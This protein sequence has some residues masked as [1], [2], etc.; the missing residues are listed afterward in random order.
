MGFFAK[1]LFFHISH[2]L[3]LGSKKPLETS[4]LL[5]LPKK[6]ECKK[7]TKRFNRQYLLA[8]KKKKGLI[9][10]LNRT[11]GKAFWPG[12]I[13][14]LLSTTFT[15]LT[16]LF[17][18]KILEVIEG[19]SDDY[20][21]KGMPYVFSFLITVFVQGITNSKV[22]LISETTSYRIRSV[23]ISAI[24]QKSLK[25]NRKTLD[26]SKL[27]L[28]KEKGNDKEKEK[29]KEKEKIESSNDEGKIKRKSERKADKAKKTEK[30]TAKEKEKEKENAEATLGQIVNLMSTDIDKIQF[31]MKF[32]LSMIGMII[33]I[34]VSLILLVNYLGWAAVI[35]LGVLLLN[36][37]MN[38]FCLNKWFGLHTSIMTKADLRIKR[39]NE[40]LQAIKLIKLYAWEKIFKKKVV[41]IREEELTY[42]KSLMMWRIVFLMIWICLPLF[43][44]I[45]TYFS[46]VALGNKLTP[47]KVFT[48]LSLF[49]ILR[50]PL[51]L[52]PE[53]MSLVVS[54]KVS[55]IRIENFLSFEEIDQES[56][57]LQKTRIVDDQKS[58]EKKIT[59]KLKNAS[60]SWN[61]TEEELESSSSKTNN[62]ANP[63]LD[64][65]TDSS[66]DQTSRMTSGSEA[67]DGEEKGQNNTSNTLSDITLEI[68]PHHLTIIVGPVGSGKSSLLSAI[69]GEIPKTKGK[70]QV[71]G[72][73][74]YSSQE[75]WIRNSTLR[76]NILWQNEYNVRRYN[77][78][79]NIC[80]LE[81]DL[82]M[83]PAGDLTEIGEKG[84]NL[85]GG[86]KARVS[87]AR[88]VYSD[89]DI[90]LL[91][92]PLSAIDVHVGKHI[93]HKCIKG[94][95]LQNK[96][97]VLVTHQLQYLP[98][99]DQLIIIDSGKVIA[100]GTYHELK[101]QD[102]DFTK[103]LTSQSKN[104][105][106]KKKKNM[107]KN[108]KNNNNK[109]K[110]K[111]KKKNIKNKNIKKNKDGDDN[112]MKDNGGDEK[113]ISKEKNDMLWVNLNENEKY[114]QEEIKV[115][116]Q[117]ETASKSNHTS[118]NKGKLIN[119]E[120][121]EIGKVKMDHY[122]FYI[123]AAGKYIALFGFL[124]IVLSMLMGTAINFWLAIWT[125]GTIIKN[126]S[127]EYYITWYF[128]FGI[129]SVIVTFIQGY[130]SAVGSVNA[131]RNIHNNLFDRISTSP[132]K[133]F[134]IT[135]IG[136][137]LNRFNKDIAC[138][139]TELNDGLFSVV[140]STLIVFGIL[141][142]IAIVTPI[143][144]LP[145]IAIVYLYYKIINYFRQT[146]REI[147]RL[148]SI[149]RSPVFSNF[150]ETLNGLQ[151]IRA[152][153][154]Q[155]WMVRENEGIVNRLIEIEHSKILT[156]CWLEIRLQFCGAI[157]IFFASLFALLARNTISAA[158]AALSIQR[159]MSV[160]FL[161]NWMV[162]EIADLERKMNSIE[163]IRDYT[164]LAKE[165]PY[166]IPKSKPPKAWPKR[167]KI[168]FQ[169]L[170][171]K[172]R[173]EL[174]P[175]LKNISLTIEPTEKI[176]VI[177]RTGSGK[178]SLMMCLFRIVEY[179]KGKILIDGVDIAKMGLY[180][181]RS[182]LGII[183][184][185]PIL[186]EG[187][188][189]SNL[190]PYSDSES[191][192][193]L[194]KRKSDLELWEA[195]HCAQL[196][197]KVQSLKGQLDFQI[198]E[199]GDNFSVGEK[200]LFCLARA[201][202]KNAQILILDEA[203]ANVDSKT[204]NIIQQTIRTKFKMCTVITI[205]HRLN[206]VMDSDKILALE[207]GKV[208]EFDKPKKLLKNPKGLLY[209]LVE[210]T[211]NEN[212]QY[213]R[214]IAF[215]AIKI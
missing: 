161:S 200:Q 85:S 145:T 116:T 202:L 88:A 39:V 169:N 120:E 174:E 24:F 64:N 196:K 5:Q 31:A 99:A 53:L 190:D 211:G 32:F 23:L 181:L 182:K 141:I 153:N 41:S 201:V 186:F 175:V 213:L 60:F 12:L 212:S 46:Y 37:P 42:V 98:F 22:N 119:F 118:Q 189:R 135:P 199:G 156:E 184:Q 129:I 55:V 188:I 204:D 57:E 155:E 7:L 29:E 8:Q 104:N 113:T 164:E 87:L 26:L 1:L 203:T 133:F 140:A 72:T 128:I 92:D 106:K 138:V 13:P 14:A 93:F 123:K 173:P 77:K 197:K 198:T 74:A 70:M 59:I 102:F 15:L 114:F 109:N 52:V 27:K 83:L 134:E 9:W 142:T 183:P 167:G 168:E 61:K 209:R 180:D 79:K 137:M 191:H 163:R 94:E 6:E 51:T 172:Y 89:R 165:A 80:G 210:E 16:P 103:Y 146:S 82:E 84:V 91:D 177:G 73:I 185:D 108:I 58:K 2:L 159:A 110:N 127:N 30:E 50:I 75:S 81:H 148:Q 100:K 195:L 214:N 47:V 132:M 10:S 158:L 18:M 34:I 206:T 124:V 194:G 35:G 157:V 208:K 40:F 170:K 187:T 3:K 160:I 78:I 192:R 62:N 152:F 95:L 151:T 56:Q 69:L 67:L 112:K 176:G 193:D 131:S 68:L 44:T 19:T 45:A 215:G 126:K 162:Q 4:D 205:A 33:Q 154:N 144:L 125:D 147:K 76:K 48:S 25:I 63:N 130:C 36:F 101:N 149:A 171:M 96:T 66:N 97:I 150:S 43:V 71:K 49:D 139:D 117:N 107:K 20:L 65:G 178:S 121:R 166:K 28:D 111:N 54:G 11:F 17:L 90:L 179:Y 86:Q 143:F 207:N 105:Q 115:I 122:K 136:R 21:K 38:F